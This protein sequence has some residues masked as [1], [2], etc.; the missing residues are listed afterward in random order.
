MRGLTE[1]TAT[2][3]Q[4]SDNESEYLPSRLAS[5]RRPSMSPLEDEVSTVSGASEQSTFLPLTPTL[6][7]TTITTTPADP[8][9]PKLA[10]INEH[11]NNDNLRAAYQLLSTTTRGS[12]WQATATRESLIKV[13]NYTKLLGDGKKQCLEQ[14]NIINDGRRREMELEAE[15]KKLA[16]ELARLR[17]ERN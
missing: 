10:K 3:N 8:L 7:T 6:P 13:Y 17:A 11:I 12:N 5:P 15:V 9:S 14:A 1:P 16:T 4:D 2:N